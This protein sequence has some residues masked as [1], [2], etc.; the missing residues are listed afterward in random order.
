MLLVKTKLGLSKIHGIGLFA[1]EP[2]KKGT[3]IWKFAPGLDL[4]FSEDL[5]RSIEHKEQ[6]KDYV[7][8][9]VNTKKFVLCCDDA[10][11]MNH[12]EDPNVR[13]IW[14]DENDDGTTIASRQIA[15]GEE[16]TCNYKVFDADWKRKLKVNNG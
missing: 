13:D 9:D 10:R 7:Y 2:I 1:N 8:L 15:I 12:S 4:K 5:M 14:E 16:I 6:I 3:P 11:F